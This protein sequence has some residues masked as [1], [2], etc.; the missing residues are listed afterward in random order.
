MDNLANACLEIFGQILDMTQSI[1]GWNN[2][3]ISWLVINMTHVLHA[4]DFVGAAFFTL[5]LSPYWMVSIFFCCVEIGCITISILICIFIPV[6][7]LF[8]VFF[9]WVPFL[10][11][12][13]FLPLSSPF[14]TRFR[15]GLYHIAYNNIIS[16]CCFIYFC[17]LDCAMLAFSLS[18]SLSL[19]CVVAFSHDSFAWCRWLNGSLQ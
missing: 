13:R 14:F 6:Y 16:G 4:F 8:S 15:F 11:L 5:S 18:L 9:V 10:L 19:V 3:F 2:L 7:A 1:N 17:R 12:F